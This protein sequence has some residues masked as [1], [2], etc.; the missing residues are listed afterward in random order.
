MG[1]DVT[2]YALNIQ[3]NGGGNPGSINYT[4]VYLIAK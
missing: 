3:L 2:S 4:F 1:R